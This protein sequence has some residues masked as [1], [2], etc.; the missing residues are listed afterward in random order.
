MKDAVLEDS[1]LLLG[2]THEILNEV[3]EELQREYPGFDFATATNLDEIR[4]ADA[5][6]KER[7]RT[8]GYLIAGSGIS[9]ETFVSAF[10]M[11][12]GELALDPSVCRKGL[13]PSAKAFRPFAIAMVAGFAAYQAGIAGLSD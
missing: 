12:K 2:R 8:I 6:A 9:D 4:A 3:R 5:A 13:H 10:E 11:M 7:G 1:V